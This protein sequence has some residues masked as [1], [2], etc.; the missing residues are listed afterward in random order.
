MSSADADSQH[1]WAEDV[2]D[3]V[4]VVSLDDSVPPSY[5][6]MA[7]PGR[8]SRVLSKSM[9]DDLIHFER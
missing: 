3:D 5:A 9:E 8:S 2:L 4:S 1:S 6:Q 7:G